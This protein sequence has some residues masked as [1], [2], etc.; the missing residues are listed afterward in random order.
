MAGGPKTTRAPGEPARTPSQS[1]SAHPL[2]VLQ[3]VLLALLV[4][5]LVGV[6]VGLV[7]LLA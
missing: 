2:T 7:S 5:L 6:T 4:G 1:R 3:I